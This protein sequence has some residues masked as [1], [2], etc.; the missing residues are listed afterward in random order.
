M[1]EFFLEML[2]TAKKPMLKVEAV[3]NSCV[4]SAFNLQSPVIISVTDIGRVSRMI[5]KY[6]P[7]SQVIV[8][9]KSE[10]LANQSCLSRSLNGL[11]VND[12]KNVNLMIISL[13]KIMREAGDVVEN[14]DIVFVSGVMDD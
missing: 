2:T 3:A 4:K 10:R 6:K 12:I 14:D 5:S 7:Y 9:S 1:Y 11:V 8:I 13:M